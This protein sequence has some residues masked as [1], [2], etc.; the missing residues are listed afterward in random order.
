MYKEVIL[1]LCAFLRT[2]CGTEVTLD[3]LDFTSLSTVGRIQWLDMQ[4]ESLSRSSDK[5]LILCSPG[6]Y[7]K[8]KSLC[9]GNRVM[10]RED[11]RS[12]MGDMLTPA[13][14]LI[15]PDFVH[16]LSFQK[17]IVAYFDD[18]CSENDVPGPFHVAVK[19]RLMKHFEE[20]FFRLVDKE[21][22]EPGRI[23]HVQGIGEDDYFN[24]SPGTALRDA[25]N[26]FKAYQFKNPN[27]FEMELVGADEEVEESGYEPDSG[28]EINCA[29][30][31]Q[32]QLW[33]KDIAGHI[34]VNNIEGSLHELEPPN[35]EYTAS[36]FYSNEIYPTMPLYSH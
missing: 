31:L 4:R 11:V 10:T 17:Y 26:A 6:V 9:G 19:Y 30:I 3:L 12:C 13:L 24:S 36:N 5:V 34:F 8:W 35:G 21:K 14:S 2:K 22:H 25:I 20:L 7:A 1:K 28:A 18:V 15:V 27:W 23:K 16:S 33:A 32:N 29:C